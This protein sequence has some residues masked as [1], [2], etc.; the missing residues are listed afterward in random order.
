MRQ[1]MT[2]GKVYRLRKYFYDYMRYINI[3][4]YHVKFRNLIQYIKNIDDGLY[5]WK[6]V[7]YLVDNY[8][9]NENEMNEIHDM[10]YKYELTFNDTYMIIWRN[11]H[12][13][14]NN[15]IGF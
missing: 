15:I 7:Q 14:D 6:F 5:C 9:L 2:I 4:N 1:I 3:H 11:E 8:E 13:L 10:Y 12:Y